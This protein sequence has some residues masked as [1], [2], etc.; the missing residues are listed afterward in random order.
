MSEPA[1]GVIAMIVACTIWG[2]SPLYYA[3]IRD[4]PP[5]EVLCYRAIWSFIFFAIILLIQRRMRM[6]WNAVSQLE[7]LW[8]I[9]LVGLLISSNWGV[10]IYAIGV[11]KGVDASLGYYMFP[12][13]TAALGYLVFAERLS[14]IQWVAI[15]LS[16]LAVVVLSIGLQVIPF[17]ALYLGGSFAAYGALKKRL[18]IGPVISVTAE[19]LILLPI[20][21]LFLGAFGSQLDAGY[22]RQA[23]LALSGPITAFPLILLSFAARRIKLSTVGVVSLLNPTLQFGCAVIVFLE[24]FTIWHGIAFPLMWGALIIYSISQIRQDRASRN[25]V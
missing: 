15:G 14:Q 4:V 1:K 7:N 18:T 10:F 9:A 11:E 16:A 19:V 17:I 22:E 3:Q 6:V 20:A 8:V 12:L 13:M 24:P 5:L 23:Y 21:V 2:L 25:A